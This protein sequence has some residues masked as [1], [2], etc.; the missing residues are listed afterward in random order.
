MIAVAAEHVRQLRHRQHLGLL[1]QFLI[2]AAATVPGH[3]NHLID[4]EEPLIKRREGVWQFSLSA[5][6][7]HNVASPRRRQP[8][9]PSKPM[10]GRSDAVLRPQIADERLNR[11]IDELGMQQIERPTHAIQALLKVINQLIHAIDSTYVRN[12]RQSRKAQL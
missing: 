5:G 9:L 2:V 10:L 11:E 12:V 3:D 7:Q 6:H 4:R 8:R 1:D